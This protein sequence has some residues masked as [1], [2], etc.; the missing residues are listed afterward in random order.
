MMLSSSTTVLNSS[1]NPPPCDADWNTIAVSV[2]IHCEQ[3]DREKPDQ[4]SCKHRC[5]LQPMVE[6]ACAVQHDRG[7]ALSVPFITAPN[8]PCRPPKE[9]EKRHNSGR[10]EQFGAHL[11]NLRS[12]V[13][14][15]VFLDLVRVDHSDHGF[16]LH[17]VEPMPLSP[18]Q[19][20]GGWSN[21]GG[22]HLTLALRLPHR[23]C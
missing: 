3:L 19:L 1:G 9:R 11:C 16:K 2:G 6:T 18:I 15:H 10:L 21:V 7:H 20:L 23:A 5:K 4:P 13:M 22:S 17:N 8:S 14:K 12:R